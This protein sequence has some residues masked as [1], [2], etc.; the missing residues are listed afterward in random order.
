MPPEDALRG[1][2]KRC[3]RMHFA[4]QY[5]DEAHLRVAH[6]PTATIERTPARRRCRNRYSVQKHVSHARATSDLF[7]SV[8][9]DWKVQRKIVQSLFD[10]GVPAHRV[11]SHTTCAGHRVKINHAS[12]AS[13]PPLAVVVGDGL[14][15][16][17]V[18]RSLGVAGIPVLAV[19]TDR[20]SPSALSRFASTIQS[21]KTSGAELIATLLRIAGDA[22]KAPILFLT[23]EASVRTVSEARDALSAKMTIRLPSHAILTD[24]MH[25]E[26]FQMHAEQ[27][28]A[29]IPRLVRLTT[30]ADL[31]HLHRLRFPCVLKPAY[32]DYSYGDRF[33][34]AYVVES[35]SEVRQLWEMISPVMSDLVVQEWIDGEDSE[36]FFCLQYV[37]DGKVVASF[38]G[39][40][41][42]SWPP[43]IGGTASCT[44]AWEHGEILQALTADFFLRVGFE[45]MGSME[46]KRD[47]HSG[48]FYMIEPTVARTDFQQEVATLNGV[49][50]PAIAYRHETGMGQPAQLIP[51][52]PR[53]WRDPVID[54]WAFQST[55]GKGRPRFDSLRVVDA[56]FR[57]Q[58]PMPWLEFMRVRVVDKVRAL[59]RR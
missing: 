21:P 27:A 38:P 57:W 28:G 29:P 22:P 34:K 8:P 5:R 4:R 25:K 47:V 16:L 59:T 1:R 7:Q 19:V 31:E 30:P 56:Y 40:K 3:H 26:Q 11:A 55:G 52:V 13:N 48:R 54:R 2:D 35:A 58:D 14:N 50:V 6:F 39:R 32:K 41:I 42:R 9:N 17:G 46:Y 49:N 24:L 12:G 37:A 45:G 33:K 23:E 18:V 43:R 36:I 44:S 51:M 10:P 20:R 15:A 53:V